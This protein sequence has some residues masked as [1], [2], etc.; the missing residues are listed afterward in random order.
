MEP[1]L[2]R[3]P[4]A[5]L[6][7]IFLYMGVTSLS[8]IQLFDRILLL[9]KPPKYHPDVPFVK[10]VR[11][12][13][14]I[15]PGWGRSVRTGQPLTSASPQ[16]KTWRMHLFTVIQIVCLAGLWA[17]KSSSASLALPFVLILTVPL[18]RF[19][20]PLIFS[21]LE[22]QSVSRGGPGW[23]DRGWRGTAGSPVVWRAR[24]GAGETVESCGFR[25]RDV[26]QLVGDLP[27]VHRILGSIPNTAETVCGG[28]RL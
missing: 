2:S 19:L 8:G 3:I 23:E 28:T 5:V 6:F 7:G 27:P 18:R 9:F 10:R 4:L 11:G 25:H 24:L 20:L 26:V 16:V 22:L 13:E 14:G 21:G 15:P 17:V 12:F 1:I